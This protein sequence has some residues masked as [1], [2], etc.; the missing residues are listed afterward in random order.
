MDNKIIPAGETVTF[1]TTNFDDIFHKRY[2]EV[3]AGFTL[4]CE[5]DAANRIEESNERNNSFTRAMKL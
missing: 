1:Q 4:T 5:I 3:A 2:S